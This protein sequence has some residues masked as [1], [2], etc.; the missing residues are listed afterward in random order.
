MSI[1][2][3]KITKINKDGFVSGSLMTS[4]PW[5]ALADFAIKNKISLNENKE[6]LKIA[7]LKINQGDKLNL[8]FKS[9]VFFSD[10]QHVFSLC[11][12]KTIITDSVI[13]IELS[14]LC[15]PTYSDNKYL[16]ALQTTVSKLHHLSGGDIRIGKVVAVMASRDVNHPLWRSRITP[17]KNKKVSL[18]MI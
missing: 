4:S 11:E 8:K 10:F 12:I 5:L 14:P 18:E 2:T 1:K 9:S 6:S 7:I 13:N 3:Y 17:H 15:Q 16:K